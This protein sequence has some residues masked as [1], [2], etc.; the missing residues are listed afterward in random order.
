MATKLTKD[1]LNWPISLVPRWQ[2]ALGRS[3][4]QRYYGYIVTADGQ[5]LGRTLIY[6]GFTRAHELPVKTRDDPASKPT[7]ELKDLQ[8]DARISRR[9]IWAKSSIGVY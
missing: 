9:G 5:D 6:E 4:I 1:L 3:N 7:N 2:K 8:R